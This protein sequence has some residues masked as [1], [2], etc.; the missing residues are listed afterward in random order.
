MIERKYRKPQPTKRKGKLL[1]YFSRFRKPKVPIPKKAGQYG[2]V[3]I[4][5][6]TNKED[7]KWIKYDSRK[8][9][10]RQL[11][12]LKKDYT[13]KSYSVMFMG[14]GSYV[15]FTDKQY[16]DVLGLETQ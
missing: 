9:F 15:E 3:K 8:S 5:D 11:G 14:Y 7:D 16:F 10:T 6:K 12:K 2:I 4:I 1:K 13:I